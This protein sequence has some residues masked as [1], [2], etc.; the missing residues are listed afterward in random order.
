V[1]DGFI[2]TG[3]F[4]NGIKEGKGVLQIEDST[5]VLNSLFVNNAPEYE[6][7]KFTCEILGPKLEEV[8]IDPKAKPQKDAPK[9]VTKFS[10]QEEAIYG[11]NKIYYE[12]KRSAVS[13]EGSSLDIGAAGGQEPEI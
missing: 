6:C 9:V 3:S 10:E 5:Y 11:P 1:K 12:F 2:Y 8:T 4:V 13:I 7:N